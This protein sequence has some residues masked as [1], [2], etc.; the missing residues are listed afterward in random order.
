MIN[1]RQLLQ[2]IRTCE[3]SSVL[4]RSH[5][6]NDIIRKLSASVRGCHVTGIYVRVLMY[7]VDQLLIS[8]V[9]SDLRRM[10]KICEYEMK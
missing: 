2:K 9:C 1:R 5:F 8:S 4:S 3:S 10:T 6:V 7:A